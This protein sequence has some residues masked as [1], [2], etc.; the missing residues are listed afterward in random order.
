MTVIFVHIP[1]CG[2][3]TLG[4]ILKRVYPKRRRFDVS[5]VNQKEFGRAWVDIPRRERQDFAVQALG[6]LSKRKRE[7]LDLVFGHLPY[8]VH[9]SLYGTTKYI[10]MA[11]APLDRLR[12]HYAYVQS[13][14]T[15]PHKSLIRNNSLDLS[16]FVMS[17]I[18]YS[19]DNDMVRQI[20]G[21]GETVPFGEITQVHLDT[22]IRHIDQNF[23]VAGTMERFDETLAML[24]QQLGWSKIPNYRRKNVG[25]EVTLGNWAL[26]P[27]TQARVVSFNWAD[28]ALYDHIKRRF[29][30]S[31]QT[32]GHEF[33]QEVARIKT[34]SSSESWNKIGRVLTG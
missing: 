30:M 34:A 15:H 19:T 6:R 22:A 20:S 5:A 14:P 18:S 1:R 13:L 24:K 29:E 33:H 12:S 7:T 26:D 11:R 17:G 32:Q 16:G 10:T 23:A 3:T 25:D 8:G 27:E 21:V 2:G 4:S 9:G 28:M 31:L